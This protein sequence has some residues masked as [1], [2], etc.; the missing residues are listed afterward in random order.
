MR[1]RFLVLAATAVSLALVGALIAQQSLPPAPRPDVLITTKDLMAGLSNPTRW[2]TYSGDYSGQRHSPLKQITP[3]NV[4]QLSAQWTFQTGD[5][6]AHEFEATPIV[7]D[8]VSVQTG[9]LNYAW[10]STRRPAGRSGGTSAC[11]RRGRR[12]RSAA[13]SSTAASRSTAI[14]CS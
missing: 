9:P 1:A 8:G 12:S 13:A 14:A 3:A 5:L 4:G 11:C 6:P 10:A 2:L 7:I